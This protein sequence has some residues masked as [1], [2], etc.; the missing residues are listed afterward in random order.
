M[1]SVKCSWQSTCPYYETVTSYG[2]ETIKCGN[3]DCPLF[4][5]EKER[6]EQEEGE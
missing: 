5:I 4:A 3:T 2:R 1:N 6:E